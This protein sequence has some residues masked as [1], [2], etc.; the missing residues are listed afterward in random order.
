MKN[1]EVDLSQLRDA[2]GK[3]PANIKREVR[4]AMGEQITKVRDMGRRNHRYMS[5]SGYRPT[6]RYYK[7]TGKLEQSTMSH[8]N[9]DGD[10]AEAYLESGIASY[11][12]YVH[13]GHGSWGPDKFLDK[14]IEAQEPFIRVAIEQA[15]KRAVSESVA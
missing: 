10:V 7:N 13:E 12:K 8:V 3:L 1:I 14:A 15:V 5:T 9:A 6:G 4:K 2:F 11:G